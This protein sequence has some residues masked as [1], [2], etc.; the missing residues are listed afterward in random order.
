MSKMINQEMMY[1]KPNRDLIFKAIFGDPRN[2]ILLESLLR[3]ILKFPYDDFKELQLT[4][5][6]LIAQKKNDKLGRLDVKLKMK[7]GRIVNIEIQ[8]AKDMDMR[9]RVTYYGTRLIAD[10]LA[11]GE[12]YDELKPV[13]SIVIADYMLIPENEHYRNRYVLH[14][15]TTESTFTD[16][17]E[18]NTLE[19]RKLPQDSDGHLL[20]DWLSFLKAET[21]EDFKMVEKVNPE[22]KKAVAIVK[23][24]SQDEQMREEYEAR[25]KA[26]KDHNSRMKYFK[27]AE[28]TEQ[29]AREQGLK[30]GLEQGR[31]EEREKAEI[32]K[33]AIVKNLINANIPACEIAKYTGLSVERIAHLISK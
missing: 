19:L 27:N 9:E 12:E 20:W 11:S 13:V 15:A 21:E 29:R 22:I 10:Q 31:Q 2:I 5:T 8:V 16:L 18:I 26:L 3:S 4:N 7:N 17:L 25:E 6:E 14:D 33:L 30:R 23:E 1:M 32:E 24:L 28:Q